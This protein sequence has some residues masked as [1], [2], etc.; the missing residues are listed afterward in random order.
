MCLGER[1]VIRR[2]EL[3]PLASGVE[4]L[5]PDTEADGVTDA[6]AFKISCVPIYRCSGRL[7]SMAE[8]RKP[9]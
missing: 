3:P 4:V 1:V 7:C 2:G 5:L 9:T 8:E 6:N